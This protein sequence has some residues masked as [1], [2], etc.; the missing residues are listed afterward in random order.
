M[1]NDRI[2]MNTDPKSVTAHRG[3]DSRNPVLLT[4]SIISWGITVVS[5]EPIPTVRVTD[6][7][8]P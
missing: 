8:I 2:V 1:M 3:I 5:A 7:M 6:E 4:A